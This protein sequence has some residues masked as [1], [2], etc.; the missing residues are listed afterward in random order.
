MME[1]EQRTL[2]IKAKMEMRLQ[3]LKQQ[4][5]ADRNYNTDARD[6]LYRN[7]DVKRLAEKMETM[8]QQRGLAPEHGR[9]PLVP[10]ELVDQMVGPPKQLSGWKA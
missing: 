2:A 5:Q 9:G 10:L 6:M 3:D 1:P 7:S 4:H 8:E